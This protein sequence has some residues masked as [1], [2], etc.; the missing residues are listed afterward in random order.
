MQ[1]RRVLPH[2]AN[3]VGVFPPQSAS[4]GQTAVTRDFRSHLTTQG[5]VACSDDPRDLLQVFLEPP[6]KDRK[7]PRRSLALCTAQVRGPAEALDRI[8][9]CSRAIEE[10]VIGPRQALTARLA[11][12]LFGK[13]LFAPPR[14]EHMALVLLVDELTP[15]LG[16]VLAGVCYDHRLR[17]RIALARSHAGDLL[18]EPNSPATEALLDW[19]VTRLGPPDGATQA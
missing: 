13:S 12:T 16:P 14:R 5:L 8:L 9:A 15:W 17:V 10:L 11:G 1:V 2:R 4:Q 6:S 19:T 18:P 7:Q 3:L